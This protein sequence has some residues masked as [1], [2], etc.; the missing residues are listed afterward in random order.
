MRTITGFKMISDKMG[1]L[2]TE[3]EQKRKNRTAISKFQRA[4]RATCQLIFGRPTRKQV[5]PGGRARAKF[6]PCKTFVLL[7]AKM[8][9]I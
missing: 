5:A 9:D 6:H 2:L 7:K 8:H 3:A 4:R 1:L